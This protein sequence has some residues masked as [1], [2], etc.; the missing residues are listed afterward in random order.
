VWSIPV[1]AALVVVALAVVL[2]PDG[3]ETTTAP[4]AGLVEQG[5]AVFA[6]AG[7]GGCHT[8][9]DAGSTGTTGPNLDGLAPDAERVEAAVR[10]GRGAMPSFAATLDDEAM[11]SVAAYVAAV[12]GE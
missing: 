5:R 8:L 7:C 1:A 11:A 12:S 6:S 9:A 3:A 4:A 10:S 2:E